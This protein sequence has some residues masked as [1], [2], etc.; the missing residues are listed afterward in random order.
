MRKDG[1]RENGKEGRVGDCLNH[2]LH[3]IK[4]FTDYGRRV[5]ICS[6]G[7]ART[8]PSLRIGRG[9]LGVLWERNRAV[10]LSRAL[11]ACLI[12]IHSFDPLWSF[13]LW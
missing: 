4:D 1:R 3:R 13:D 8:S 9:N 6:A 12:V 5:D 11:F 7:G 2:R 10:S